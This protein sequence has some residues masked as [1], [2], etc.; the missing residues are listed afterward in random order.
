MQYPF[1]EKLPMVKQSILAIGPKDDLWEISLR[2][3]E[4][5]SN[6]HFERWPDH[7][8]GIFDVAKERIVEKIRSHL[9]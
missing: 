4:Y 6:G 5:I 7:G 3:E 2:S 8:F 9:D 1:A